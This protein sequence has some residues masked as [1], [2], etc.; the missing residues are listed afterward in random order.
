MPRRS[1]ADRRGPA[2]RPAI[3]LAAGGVALAGVGCAALAPQPVTGADVAAVLRASFVPRGGAGMERIEQ[4]TMQ[5]ECS[6]H[7]SVDLAEPVRQRIEA[8]ALARV[9]YPTDGRYLGDWRR[10]EAIA[11]NGRGLQYDDAPGTPN[12]GNCYACHRLSAEEISFGNTGPSLFNYGKLRGSSE[13]VVKYTWARIW[14][15]H[16]FN[17]CSQ[18]PRFGDAGILTAEQIR[19][20]MALLLDP[21]SPVNR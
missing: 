18:M 17:A 12:G 14:N 21:A 11:Q 5:K 4:S 8:E 10:G 16:S 15:S 13:P 1:S 3:A 19:D 7:V 20:L 9:P 2:R 6:H